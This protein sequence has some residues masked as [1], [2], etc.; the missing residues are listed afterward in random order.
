MATFKTRT[1]RNASL[2]SSAN[3]AHVIIT[4][5]ASSLYPHRHSLLFCPHHHAI[6]QL[7]SWQ[8]YFRAL[9]KHSHDHC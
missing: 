3:S 4:P 5:P 1:G 7:L 9:A 8:H 6:T 2:R